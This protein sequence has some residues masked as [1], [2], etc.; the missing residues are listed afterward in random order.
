M[1]R[2]YPLEQGSVVVVETRIT[3]ERVDELLQFLPSFQTPGRRFIRK[4]SGGKETVNGAI[5][6]PYPEYEH[7]VLQ[8]FHLAAQPCWSDYDYEPRAAAG[9]LE[10]HEFVRGCSLDDIRT[11]LT[12]CVRGERFSDGFWASLLQSGRVI[13]LLRRLAVLR[14]TLPG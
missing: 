6:M 14:D 1:V 8:F 11:M 13:A 4:W 10:D 12:F 3:R 5:T 9:M 2:S 7:D